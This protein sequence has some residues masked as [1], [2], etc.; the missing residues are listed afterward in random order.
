[1]KFPPLLLSLLTAV[2]AWADGV[3]VVQGYQTTGRGN[4]QALL[5]RM[6]FAGDKPIAQ[7]TFRLK[8]DTR[9]N[10]AGVQLYASN[11]DE[12]FADSLPTLK[13]QASAAE[14]F[15]LP[16][17]QWDGQ[18]LWLTTR[19]KGDA[20]PGQSIDA[21]LTRIDYQDGTSM[22]VPDSI[23]DPDGEAQIFATQSLAFVPT[24]SDCR[25]YRI[26]AMVVDC[27]GNLLVAADR[28]YDSNADLGNHKIDVAVRRS[29]DGGR[30]WSAQQIIAQGDGTT[31]ACYGYGDPAL[32][33]AT[34]GRI[35]CLMAAG[36]KGYFQ[37]MRNMGL[38]MSDDN[39]ATWT[40]VRDLMASHFR[41]ATH[42]TTDSLGFWSIFTTSGKGLTTLDGTI[43]FAANTLKEAGNYQSDCY[44]ISSR[45]EGEHWQLG[46]A[47]AFAAGDESKLEQMGND[48]LLISVRRR[49]ARGFNLGS[50]DGS[51]WQEQ[52]NNADITNGNACNADMLR[53]DG[54]MMLHTYLNHPTHRANLVLAMSNDDGRS[55]H[56][57]MTI[58]PGGAAYSTMVRMPNG[59]VGILYEDESYSAGN[60]YALTFVT[61]TRQQILTAA[62]AMSSATSPNR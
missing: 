54:S 49:G 12:F 7:L 34:S 27:E 43:M 19:V 21:A 10:I 2:T 61:I 53:Y 36:R 60:G 16:L 52:W 26:P 40:P 39:G 23:G 25:F 31:D 55:W 50:K 15:S 42:G 8:G 4:E 37:G 38:T 33:V 57:V 20:T 22:N 35:V 48:S 30:S 46:P 47:L 11:A 24:T 56:D 13:G 29:H 9:K 14:S 59:D 28:R 45:D 1:L 5:L 62:R 44:V 17:K 6:D 3:T 32:A 41:D 18:R 51:R 58:Q